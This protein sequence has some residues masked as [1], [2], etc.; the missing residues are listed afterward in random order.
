[1]FV[2]ESARL[3]HEII[4]QLSL[5]TG[6]EGSLKTCYDTSSKDMT[7]YFDDR[8]DKMRCIALRKVVGHRGKR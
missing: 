8:L 1:M 7:G 3:I 5:S 4:T 6:R 2:E